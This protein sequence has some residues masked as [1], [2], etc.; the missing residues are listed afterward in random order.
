[1][2]SIDILFDNHRS[3]GLKFCFHCRYVCCTKSVLREG[4]RQCFH[5]FVKMPVF[6]LQPFMQAIELL[7]RV[8]C[9]T[10]KEGGNEFCLV[11]DQAGHVQTHH[12]GHAGR[13][14]YGN[15]TGAR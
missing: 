10:A 14:A 6:K 1:M 8:G 11:I 12:S 13:P 2:A 4:A 15:G 9:R 3:P 7:V 5:N